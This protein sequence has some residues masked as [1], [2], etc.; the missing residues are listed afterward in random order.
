[1]IFTVR[2]SLYNIHFTIFTVRYIHLTIFTL[3]QSLYD[4]HFTIFTLRYIH[5]MTYSRYDIH[6]TIYS[7]YDSHFTIVTVRYSLHDIHCTIFNTDFLNSKLFY[8]TKC[9]KSR[10]LIHTGTISIFCIHYTTVLRKLM[11]HFKASLIPAVCQQETSINHHASLHFPLTSKRS[12]ACSKRAA[13]K[14]AQLDCQLNVLCAS[15]SCFFF[16]QEVPVTIV[17]I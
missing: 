16:L 9:V 8:I 10:Q 6:C 7:L 3:R 12:S 14:D 17:L 4:I 13:Y 15:F 11:Q 2:Y 1:M 5:F